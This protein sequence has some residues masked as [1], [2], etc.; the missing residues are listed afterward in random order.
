MTHRLD[1]NW[2][3]HTIQSGPGSNGNEGVLHTGASPLVI[4]YR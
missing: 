4:Q 3:Y 2:Y 1:P